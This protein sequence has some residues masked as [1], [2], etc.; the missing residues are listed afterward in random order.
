M[1]PPLPGAGASPGAEAAAIRIYASRL[2][3]ALLALPCGYLAVVGW[4]SLATGMGD[5]SLALGLIA[6]GLGGAVVLLAMGFSRQPVLTIDA[7]GLHCRRPP[8]GFVPWA[9]I[10]GIGLGRAPLARTALILAIDERALTPEAAERVKRER[11]SLLSGPE[12]N[13]YRGRMAGYPTVPISIALLA[14]TPRE[15]R[16]ILESEIRYDGAPA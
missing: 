13:R 12:A 11:S 10:A 15:L 8:L 4:R 1:N 14:I 3:H 7:G 16:R 6:F 9:A 5:S 2:K